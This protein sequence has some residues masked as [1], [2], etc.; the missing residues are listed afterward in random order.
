MD[1]AATEHY[2]TWIQPTTYIIDTEH[3]SIWTQPPKDVTLQLINTT[4]DGR[5]A[6][7]HYITWIQLPTDTL[8]L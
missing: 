5:Y 4:A 3:I 2:S 8:V 6:T 1:V 7:E